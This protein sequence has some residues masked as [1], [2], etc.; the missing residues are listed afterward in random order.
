MDSVFC[1]VADIHLS[2]FIEERVNTDTLP[3][4]KLELSEDVQ[5]TDGGTGPFHGSLL[6]ITSGRGTRPSSVVAV[7]PQ[8]PYNTTVLWN[9]YYGRQFNSLND[10]KIHPS[11][12]IFVTDAP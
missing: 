4:S 5:M 6:L 3:G 8:P 9:N 7:N 2:Y 10:A 1:L 11:G 12:K